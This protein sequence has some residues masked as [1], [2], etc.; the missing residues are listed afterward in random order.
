VSSSGVA[1]VVDGGI[2]VDDGAWLVVVVVAD[3][4]DGSDVSGG[5]EE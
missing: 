2:V 3:E 5:V 1:N 4:S